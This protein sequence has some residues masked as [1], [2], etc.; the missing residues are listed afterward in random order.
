MAI[1]PGEQFIRYWLHQFKTALQGSEVTFLMK[2][3]R[4]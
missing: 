3:L 2:R 1:I 4:K